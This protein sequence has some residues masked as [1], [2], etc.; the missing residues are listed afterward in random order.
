[1]TV[2]D[3]LSTGVDNLFG[4]TI[5]VRITFILIPVAMVFQFCGIGTGAWS[6]SD[7]SSQGLLWYCYTSGDLS[8]C[9]HI[10]DKIGYIPGIYIYLYIYTVRIDI[11]NFIQ[12][13]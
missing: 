13:E 6:D 4:C 3:K 10:A 1:M 12:L 5:P 8:C 9:Q 11:T 2:A 7:E